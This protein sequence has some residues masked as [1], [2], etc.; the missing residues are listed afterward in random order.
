MLLQSQQQLEKYPS[1]ASFEHT[2]Y[3]T[4]KTSAFTT[5]H[6]RMDDTRSRLAITRDVNMRDGN[7]LRCPSRLDRAAAMR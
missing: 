2:T 6:R 5:Q 3:G 4:K 1:I 7:A